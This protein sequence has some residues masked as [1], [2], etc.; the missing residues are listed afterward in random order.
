MHST[1]N[2]P[3]LAILKKK[4]V[5]FSKKTKLERFEKSHYFICIL[6]QIFYNLV[7]KNFQGQIHP[8]TSLRSQS[9]TL[10][11]ASQRKE[12]MS[13]LSVLSG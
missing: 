7:M 12:T 5:F 4:N 9:R 10:S 1:A 13:Y 3:L 8:D 6:R 2:L 11:L